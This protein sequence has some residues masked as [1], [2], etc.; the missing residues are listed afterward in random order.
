MGRGRRPRLPPWR[1][2]E[3]IKLGTTFIIRHWIPRCSAVDHPAAG[4]PASWRDLVRSIERR[5]RFGPRSRDIFLSSPWDAS[6][7]FVSYL[8]ENS[9]AGFSL[10]EKAFPIRNVALVIVVANFSLYYLYYGGL[11]FLS[12]STGIG[13]GKN[14]PALPPP[15]VSWKQRVE[16]D[17]LWK[18]VG[19]LV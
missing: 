9:L 10:F 8:A 3:T 1:R 12:M 11:L 6:R 4:N 5:F 19:W 17:L 7:R 15:H 18:S 2:E 13:A 16:R 14:I